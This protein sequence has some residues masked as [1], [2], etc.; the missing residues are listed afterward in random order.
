VDDETLR[1]GDAMIFAGGDVVSGPATVVEAIAHGKIA[2]RMIDL[3]LNGNK[4]ERSYH[5][6]R[7]AM[8]VEPVTLTEEEIETLTRPE[9]PVLSVSERLKGFEEVEKG[10]TEEQAMKEARRCLRCDL[11][12]QKENGG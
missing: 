6:T 12:I 3:Y 2:A 8:F 7:P 11:E 5:V 9:M 10:F 4:V 1:T